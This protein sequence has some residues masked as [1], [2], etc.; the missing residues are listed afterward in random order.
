MRMSE[1]EA[2][3]REILKIREE[4]E[5]KI[6]NHNTLVNVGIVRDWLTRI[7]AVNK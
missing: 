1:N 4:I 3:T 6:K 2:V 7:K 5:E